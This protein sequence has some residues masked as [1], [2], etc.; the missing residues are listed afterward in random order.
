LATEKETPLN[1]AVRSMRPAIVIAIIFSLFINVL[2]LISPIYMLQVYDRVLTSRSEMTLLFITLIVVMLFMVYSALE[3]L[4]TRVLVRAGIKFDAELRGDVFQSVL[5]TTLTRRGAGAQAFRDVDTVRE[6]MTGSGLLTFCD[7]PWVPVFIIACFMLHWMFGVLA[8]VGGVLILGLAITNDLVTRAPLQRATSA[9]IGAQNEA[10]TTMRNAEVMHAMG[11]WK[12]LQ[13]R[14]EVRRDDLIAWQASASDRGGGVM[15]TI[16]FIRQVLQTLILGGGAYL[17]LRG[18]TSAGSMVAASILVG[19]ALAPIEQAVG[20]WKGFL[21]SR[22]SWDRLQATF[23]ANGAQGER[24][25]LPTPKGRLTVEAASVTPPGTARPTLLGATF[26]LEPGSSLGVIGPSAAGKSSLVRAL[27]GV[28]PTGSGAVKVDGFDLRQWSPLQL[29]Q[30]VGYLPQDVELFSGTVADNIA[31]F[32]EFDPREVIDAARLAGV[33]EMI[34]GLASGY[35]TQIGEGGASLSGGQRQR[36]ALARALFRT[37]PLIILDE[38]NANLDADGEQALA[39]AIASVKGKSTVV[40]VT[41]KINLLALADHV[42]IM[43]NGQISH[44]GE[45]DAILRPLMAAQPVPITA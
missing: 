29:G 40:F 42:M 16:K 44:F 1:G 5:E 10:G 11:M 24:M 22:G 20:Q 38:P 17:V 3:T 30:H 37:P 32:G 33:H 34:Q 35:D 19:R 15:A 45:R 41:H 21:A 2:A 14:W 8:I 13:Q 23:R 18:Q 6:F 26:T 4:R 27:T 43:Q 36:L 9:S 7:V 31:R 28:W 12:G 25:P 39:Q